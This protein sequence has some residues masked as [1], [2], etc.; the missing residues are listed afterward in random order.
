MG[1]GTLVPIPSR[2]SHRARRGNCAP[3]GGESDASVREPYRVETSRSTPSQ[4]ES[5]VPVPL[6]G[7]RPKRGTSTVSRDPSDGASVRE[8]SRG[9]RTNRR[10][11]ASNRQESATTSELSVA[12]VCVTGLHVL[13]L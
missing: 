6:R 12:G 1:G 8:L 10:A 9:R 3:N 5:D 7:R 4:K 13:P 2:S 11:G